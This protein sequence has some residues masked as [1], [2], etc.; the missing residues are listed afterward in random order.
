M[1]WMAMALCYCG[2]LALCLAMPKHWRQVLHNEP[3][4]RRRHVLRGVGGTGLAA[5]LGMLVTTD[6]WSFG[7]V[8]WVAQLAVAALFLVLLLPHAPRLL[9]GV[10]AAGLVAAAVLLLG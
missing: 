8:E 5:S 9:L 6:G 3:A 2:W 10:G 1:R 4:P 7:P